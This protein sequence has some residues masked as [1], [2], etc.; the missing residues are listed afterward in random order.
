MKKVLL[1]F[2]GFVVVVIGGVYLFRAPIKE[3]AIAE[4][5]SDMFI[6]GDTDSFDPGLAIGDR[7]PPLLASYQGETISDMGEFISDK[8]M[9]FVANRSVDW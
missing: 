8:G 6:E 5:V 4:L 2:L 3:A 7:F 9:I 1:G